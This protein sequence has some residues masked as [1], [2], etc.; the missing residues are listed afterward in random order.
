MR[1]DERFL[2]RVAWLP[3]EC[4]NA[5]VR[6]DP[7]VHGVR[8]DAGWGRR[9]AR[10]PTQF[11]D[12]VEHPARHPG[13]RAVPGERV[14]RLRA[15]PT[16]RRDVQNRVDLGG[17]SHDDCLDEVVDVQVLRR[18][19]LVG[20]DG[21]DLA[22]KPR[23]ATRETV[24]HD[25][26]GAQDGEAHTR[27]PCT[28]GK[29]APFEFGSLHGKR[30]LGIRSDRRVLGERNRVVGPRAIDHRGRQHERVTHADTGCVLEHPHRDVD[31]VG[32]AVE[33]HGVDREPTREVHERGCAFE[34]LAQLGMREVD[35]DDRLGR[36][37]LE[38]G[39]N[40]VDRDNFMTPGAQP[41]DDTRT[42]E[43]GRAGDDDLHEVR[44]LS[45]RRNRD[46]THLRC[47]YE[48]R[49]STR[50]R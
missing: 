44:G 29:R 7:W 23:D 11:G 30:E 22:Q 20:A 9:D 8:D 10:T 12:R 26:G 19:I 5:I 37:V 1:G 41:F 14:E 28:P 4:P 39:R 46:C 36:A 47:P 3:T 48:R 17:G 24:G 31:V 40:A 50:R 49:W 45:T 42:E 2:I 15:D 16:V 6:D 34:H 25:H 27:A 21:R 38:A 33:R 35:A 32:R 18:R 13:P 43:A